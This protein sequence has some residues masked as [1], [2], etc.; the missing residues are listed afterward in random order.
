MMSIIPENEGDD[1]SSEHKAE[2]KQQSEQAQ[3]RRMTHLNQMKNQMLARL[4]EMKKKQAQ[5]KTQKKESPAEAQEVKKADNLKTPE[6]DNLRLQPMK[7]ASEPQANKKSGALLQK[8]SPIL[9]PI[10]HNDSDN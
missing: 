5:S 7:Q 9:E 8:V 4:E 2:E 1:R 10:N 3:G 6:K